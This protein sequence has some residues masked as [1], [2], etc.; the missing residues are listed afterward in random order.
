[1]FCHRHAGIQPKD[2]PSPPPI[3][4]DPLVSLLDPSDEKPSVPYLEMQCLQC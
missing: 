2:T 1:M 3:T 4:V